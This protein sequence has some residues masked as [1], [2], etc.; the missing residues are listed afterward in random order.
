MDATNGSA[1]PLIDETDVRAR[2]DALS[3]AQLEE[4]RNE[5]LLAAQGNYESLS[6]EM[7]HEM[8]YIASKLRRTN[9]GPPREPKIPGSKKARTIDDL[10]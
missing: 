8:A 4:R 10:I 6:T 7:L 9:V 5:I 1:P 2:I 3:I